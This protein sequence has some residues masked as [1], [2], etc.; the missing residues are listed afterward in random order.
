[1]GFPRKEY[2]IGLP[3]PSPEDLLD[4]EIKLMFLAS[5][6]LVGRFFTIVP[7]EKP[8]CSLPLG[9]TATAF[10]WSPEFPPK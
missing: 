5:P 10:S 3:F 7:P 8:V 4:P 1:M 2:W 9:Y 6:A